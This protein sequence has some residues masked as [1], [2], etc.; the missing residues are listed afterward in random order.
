[1]SEISTFGEH[2]T[3]KE[4]K[5][6]LKSINAAYTFGK[7]EDYLKRLDLFKSHYSF[8]WRDDQRQ[9]IDTYFTKKSKYSVINGIFGCGKTT[10]LMSLVVRSV[11]EKL[12]TL[13]EIMFISFNVCIRDEL[14]SKLRKYGFKSK[15]TVRTFDSIIFEICKNNDYPH[16][17]LPNYDGKRRFVYE[18]CRQDNFKTLKFQ[19]KVIF[20]DEVQDLEKQTLKVFQTFYPESRIVFAGDVFQSIQKEPRESLLWYLLHHTS[21][22]EEM[23]DEAGGGAAINKFY[24]KETPRVPKRILST[25]QKTLTEYYPEFSDEIAEWKSSNDISMEK[26]E[27]KRFYSYSQLFDVT[28]TFVE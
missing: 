2:S 6:F 8:P 10:L 25:L 4:M 20:I 7:K 11:M 15:V 22:V 9:V 26:T 3:I 16:M 27:W 23:T 28:K 18:L 13:E 19:P 14:K 21:G 17:D 24:M 12:Y 1:M 5:E